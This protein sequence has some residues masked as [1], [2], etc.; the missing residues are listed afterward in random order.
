MVSLM[1]FRGTARDGASESVLG[2]LLLMA[3]LAWGTAVW[4]AV[5][6]VSTAMRLLRALPGTASAGWRVNRRAFVV[7]T[8]AVALL[9]SVGSTVLAMLSFGLAFGEAETLVV[10]ALLVAGLGL[11][12]F[13]LLTLL[14]LTAGR[15]RDMGLSVWWAAL[16]TVAVAAYV[17]LALKDL[18]FDQVLFNVVLLPP[19]AWFVLTLP[20]AFVRGR[21]GPTQYGP[22]PGEWAP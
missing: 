17:Y 7:Y 20:G 16:P 21:A 2:W 6:V 15:L 8:L 12:C 11:W 13:G 14:V 18:P 10:G 22:A 5:N 1:A 19:L 4:S 9:S 3:G